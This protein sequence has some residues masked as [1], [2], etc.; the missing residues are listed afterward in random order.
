MRNLINIL[1]EKAPVV[2]TPVNLKKDIVTQV[3]KT[4]DI[5]VLQRVYKVLKAG[6]IEDRIKQVFAT[7]SDAIN[8]V[9]IVADVIMKIDAAIEEKDKFLANFPKGIVN[10]KLLVDGNLHSYLE[11]VNGHGFSRDVFAALVVH[12]A[13]RPQGVGP[14][15]LALAILNPVIKWSGR[16]EGGGDILVGKLAVEVKTTVATGGRWVNARKADMD[17][18]GIYKAIVD[19]FKAVNTAPGNRI[20]KRLA[21][22]VW[23]N[24]IRPV[25]SRDPQSFKQCVK[26]VAKG[27]IAH[28]NTA[29]Y[30]K[31]LLSG[32]EQ[33]ISNAILSIGFENYKAYSGFAGVLLV[34]NI[35]QSMQYFQDYQ[36]M[37]G[38]IKADVPYIMAPES[39]GMPKVTLSAVAPGG[40]DPAE[41]RKQK[42]AAAAAPAE[43]KASLKDPGASMPAS[44]IS[45][46]RNK[47][48]EVNLG[49]G[50]ERR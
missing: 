24:T 25:I 47:R 4:D 41:L 20:P 34:N 37:T 27:L 30:E 49:L 50:R 15:E 12:P 14:G 28:A 5:N 18:A 3:N 10:S 33:D 21:P 1:S 16:A 36:S 31:A 46:P 26:I 7:D 22:S 40:L 44:A 29:A 11:L 8:Y 23:V 9:E 35:T 48:G 2:Q 45:K 42:K 39:E 6:N 13:L 19:A 17:M 43:P 32:S 38:S